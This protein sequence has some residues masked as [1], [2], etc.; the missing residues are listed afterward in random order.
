MN[1]KKIVL[2]HPNPFSATRPYYGAPL[3]VLAISR[4]LYKEGYDIKVVHPITHKQFK[5]V[6]VEECKDAI[7]LGISSIT[8]YQIL[9]KRCCKSS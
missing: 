3:G 8:G 5:Q 7:C 2:F 1:N 9:G 4:L 6:V